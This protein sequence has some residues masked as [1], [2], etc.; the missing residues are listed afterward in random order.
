M[1]PRYEAKGLELTE[2]LL[3][4]GD[5]A[6]PSFDVCPSTGDF[7]RA[8]AA[9]GDEDEANA[10]NP[11]RFKFFGGDDEGSLEVLGRLDRVVDEDEFANR[12]GGELFPE[13]NRLGPLTVAKGETFA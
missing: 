12:D 4:D 5:F 9:K 8:T 6:R 1:L 13:A 11:E 10:S 2:L 7:E 3:P